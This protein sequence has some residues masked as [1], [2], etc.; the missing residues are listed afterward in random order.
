MSEVVD[1]VM[2]VLQKMQQDISDMRRGLEAKINDIAE[3]QVEQGET[4][5][6]MKRYMTF[7][8]GITLQHSADIADIKGRL[9][10]L[11]KEP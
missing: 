6:E 8:M 3:R 4:L 7:H 9:V 2:P 5:D 1:L 11:E 10:S